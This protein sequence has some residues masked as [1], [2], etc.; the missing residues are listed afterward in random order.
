MLLHLVKSI[1]FSFSEV[2][3]GPKG[4][5][6][7]AKNAK[8]KPKTKPSSPAVRAA[9]KIK[10]KAKKPPT[11]PPANKRVCSTTILFRLIFHKEI[12]YL[13]QIANA[14]LIV[15]VNKTA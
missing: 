6:S 11:T 12:P 2:K 1:S 7:T 8:V 9:L 10:Q 14:V 3:V 13:H 5:Q 15:I 4:A